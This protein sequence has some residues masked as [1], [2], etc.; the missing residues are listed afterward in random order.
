MKY[1]AFIHKEDNNY[2]AV[3]PDLNYT[4][5]FG[6]TFEEAISNIIEASELYCEDLKKLPKASSLKDLYTNNIEIENNATP[7]LLNIKVEKLARI[8][9]MMR[10]DLLDRI[11]QRLIKFNNNRSAYIQELIVNDLANN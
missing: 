11:P 3:V 1:I 5:S 2:L 10:K 9:I 8:N 6:S 7:Q 4:S